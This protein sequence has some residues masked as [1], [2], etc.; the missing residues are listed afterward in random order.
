VTTALVLAAAIAL[1]LLGAWGTA[2]LLA[3]LD[4]DPAERF[5]LMLA[6]FPA[7][8]GLAAFAGLLA[9]RPGPLL[10]AALCLVLGLLGWASA[11]VSPQPAPPSAEA[12]EPSSTVASSGSSPDGRSSTSDVILSGASLRAQRRIS[13]TPPECRVRSFAALRMT[14]LL[15]RLRSRTSIGAEVGPVV[16]AVAL[17]AAGALG[18]TLMTPLSAGALRIGDWVAHWFLVLV[19]LGQPLPDLRTFTNRVGDFGV[20]SRPPLYNLEGG[21]LVG[22]LDVQFWPFQLITPMLALS[23]AAAGAL[24]ARAVGGRGAACIVAPLIGLSPFLLQ[25]ASYP[26]PKMVAAGLVLLFLLLIR[27]AALARRPARARQTFVLA[28][29]CAGLAYLGH[30]TSIFYIVPTLLWLSWRRPRPLFRRP[31]RWTLATWALG[32]LA[33][34]AAFG[35]WQVWVLTTY[36]LRAMLDAN[37]ASFGVDVSETLGD[38]LLKGGVA[39]IGTLVPLPALGALARG[40]LPSV[41]Q[42][43]RFQ[44]AVLTGALGLSGCWLLVRASL[45]AP[46]SLL[47]RP[48]WL[49]TVVLC[50]FFG[51]VMLQPN[52]HD[53]GDAA[54]SMTP[55]V[56]LGLAYVAREAQSLG[57]VARRLFF[58]LVLAELACYLGLWLWWALSPAWTHDPNAVLGS[59]Y[60]LEHLRM[61]WGPATTVGALLLTAGLGTSAVLLWRALHATA[62]A[63]HDPL[64]Q[65]DSPS[66]SQGRGDVGADPEVS[67]DVGAAQRKGPHGRKD[68]GGRGVGVTAE[69]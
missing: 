69:G 42:L 33:G 37:P 7:A 23:V 43:L 64:R 49:M 10:P 46:S 28:A 6:L 3:R 55:I 16:L 27:A 2:R 30:P 18:T 50:G 48:P 17:F 61:I 38:W 47:R 8:L 14:W 57:P 22:P 40:S 54:D 15:D 52:W 12:Q 51:Q 31:V 53:T 66:P 60:G 20:I 35:P 45:A 34:L 26:W 59:R 36:G 56:V 39:A 68:G 25:N 65:L 9:G 4:L 13:P 41:D 24:W 44:L 21:L 5:A 63:Q 62:H 11:P 67:R 32:G 58:G 29:L 1:G 19:Y